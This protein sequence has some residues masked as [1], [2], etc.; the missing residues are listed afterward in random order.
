MD[1]NE[2]RRETTRS[3]VDKIE[4]EVED[5]RRGLRRFRTGMRGDYQAS[6]G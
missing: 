1:E 5:Q 2:V 6:I 3:E 4:V